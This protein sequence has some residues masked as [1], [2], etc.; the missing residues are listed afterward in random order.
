MCGSAFG[1]V[2]LSYGFTYMFEDDIVKE[3]KLPLRANYLY[4][5]V[6]FVFLTL[7]NPTLEELF[8]YKQKFNVKFKGDCF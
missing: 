6:F 2:L 8:W 5:A 7:I 4:L 1:M 3:L